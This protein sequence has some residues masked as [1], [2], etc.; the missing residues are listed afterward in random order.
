MNRITRIIAVALTL[1]MDVLETDADEAL[2]TFRDFH[3]NPQRFAQ[4]YVAVADEGTL[5]ATVCYWVRDVRGTSGQPVRIGHLYHVATHP[6]ARRQGHA[7]RILDHTIQALVRLP[8][9]FA[10]FL[11]LSIL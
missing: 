5:L 10:A 4:S 11:A 1:W 6:A 9:S 8:S 3:N 2:G 7:G